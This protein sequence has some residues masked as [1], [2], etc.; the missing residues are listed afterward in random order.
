MICFCFDGELI[1]VWV[2][3]VL[4]FGRETQLGYIFIY[5]LNILAS[6]DDRRIGQYDQSFLVQGNNFEKLFMIKL[7]RFVSH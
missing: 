1:R 3:P 6:C 2:A 4:C 5:I 7:D